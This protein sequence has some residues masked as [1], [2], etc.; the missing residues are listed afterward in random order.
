MV[1]MVMMA[2]YLVDAVVSA[3][4]NAADDELTRSG[5]MFRRVDISM[6]GCFRH[7]LGNFISIFR[8]LPS[9]SAFDISRAYLSWFNFKGGDQQKKVNLLSG[10]ERNR[11]NL[12]RTLKQVK[13]VPYIVSTI[14][15]LNT[16][17]VKYRVEP[18]FSQ[19]FFLCLVKLSPVCR[20]VHVYM[21]RFLTCNLF[22]SVNNF[23][24]R[25]RN[26]YL[27]KSG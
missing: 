11:L 22:C 26:W 6:L 19:F 20:Q 7:L 17:R 25:N 9:I 15:S 14:G 27:L 23:R 3:N 2:I 4:A 8:Y 18:C 24:M 10:G 5:W 1:M 21:Y 16:T 13:S 12:A